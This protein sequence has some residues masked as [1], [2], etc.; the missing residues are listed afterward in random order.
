MAA[1][2]SGSC[3]FMALF[4]DAADFEDDFSIRKTHEDGGNDQYND[5]EI[6]FLQIK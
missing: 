1:A 6:E 3:H 2:M 4:D 5:E